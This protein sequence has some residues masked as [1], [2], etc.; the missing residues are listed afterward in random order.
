MRATVFTNEALARH[1]GRF[2]W[3]ALD[4]EKAKNAWMRKKYPVPALPTFFIVN[5]D[6][7]KVIVRWVGGATV[8]QFDQ[9]FETQSAAW[10]A[11]GTRPDASG[12]LASADALYG[13]GDYAAAA[14]AYAA[15]I[16]DGKLNAPDD[17]R[18]REAALFSL[19]M[20]DSSEACARLA[21]E[22][23]PKLRGTTTA[24]NV[25]VS[26]LDCALQ[27][28]KEHAQRAA[29][30]G[31]LEAAS[32]EVADDPSIAA[33][34][35]DRSSLLATLASAR[36]DA[37]DEAGK[38]AA[39]ERWSAFLDDAAAKATTPEA[40]TVF[41]SHRLSAYLELGTPEKAVPMLE[42]SERAFP[43]DYNPPARLAA[44]YKAMKRWDDALAALDRAMP[45]AYG[46]RKLNFYNLRAD[47]YQGKGD[48][49]G[50]KKTLEDAIAYAESLPEGQRSQG[51]IDAFKKRLAGMT[52]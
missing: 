51:R 34:A 29:W 9:L 1:A 30:I 18:S 43:D 17:A 16:R 14:D 12:S 11:R 49:A 2:V 24:L 39:N 21:I 50:A 47:V 15:L 6:S 5:P 19:S 36:E 38:R 40:R 27:L 23:Y 7:E 35:D 45:K 3:L 31:T 37:G 52:Q 22:S 20:S 26:G 8:A 4:T 25:A 42:A 33:S 46:P 28:P 32:R 10:T 41:D 48:A 44:A 13:A